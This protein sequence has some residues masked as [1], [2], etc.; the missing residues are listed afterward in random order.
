MYPLHLCQFYYLLLCLHYQ[1]KCNMNKGKKP[2]KV[3]NTEDLNQY[4]KNQKQRV[5]ILK[6]VLSKL[7]TKSKK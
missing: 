6:K 7:K 5:E 4:L 1:T 3:D 2:F